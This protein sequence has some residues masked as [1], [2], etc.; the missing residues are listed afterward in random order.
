MLTFSNEPDHGH[1]VTLNRVH[2]VEALLAPIP[3]GT[4]VR[5]VGAGVDEVGDLALW[6]VAWRGN[7]YLALPEELRPARADEVRAVLEMAH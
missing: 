3:A 6:S 2:D 4:L 5:H 1:A 7:C